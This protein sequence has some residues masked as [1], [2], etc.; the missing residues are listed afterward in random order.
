MS[1]CFSPTQPSTNKGEGIFLTF[2][3]K[4][5]G[6]VREPPLLGEYKKTLDS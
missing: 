1:L 4:N 5:V 2:G 6:A 3:E